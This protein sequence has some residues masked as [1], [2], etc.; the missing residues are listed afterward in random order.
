[1]DNSSSLIVRLYKSLASQSWDVTFIALLLV[2]EA[3]L[4]VAIVKFVPYTEIDWEAY[5]Q[6]VSMWQDGEMDYTKIYGGTG[7]LV[8]WQVC[9][10]V[11]LISIF[12]MYQILHRLFGI[13]SIQQDFCIC[14]VSWNGL[15]MEGT[16]C[17]LANISSVDFMSLTQQSFWQFTLFL[18]DQCNPSFQRI[19]FNIITQFGLGESQWWLHVYQNESI[20][21]LCFVY[22]TMDRAWFF[23]MSPYYSLQNHIGE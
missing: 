18:G 23:S 20:Q 3:L 21:F 19:H 8:S 11:R 16:M 15:L 1:M 7:P 14:M 9:L 13:R 17:W 5:M 10:L 6:E 2:F 22:S 12:I 4:S